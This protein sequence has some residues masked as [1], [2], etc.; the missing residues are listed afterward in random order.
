ME[1]LTPMEEK[2]TSLLNL[3]HPLNFACYPPEY[4]IPP[5]LSSSSS[6]STTRNGTSAWIGQGNFNVCRA[7]LKK[8]LQ[9]TNTNPSTS[10]AS[11]WLSLP[12]PSLTLQ[13]YWVGVSE[14]YYIVHDYYGLSDTFLNMGT[15]MNMSQAFCARPYPGQDPRRGR[16]CLKSAWLSTLLLDGYASLF[17]PSN[18]SS[19]SLSSSSF[20]SNEDKDKDKEDE[21][22]ESSLF[23]GWWWSSFQNNPANTVQPK[24]KETDDAN[25]PPG[26]ATCFLNTFEVQKAKTTLMTSSTLT[27]LSS[28][29]KTIDIA[30]HLQIN[31]S[32]LLSNLSI[33]NETPE[34]PCFIP[35]Q[36]LCPWPLI[37]LNTLDQ[38]ELSWTYGALLHYQFLAPYVTF[39]TPSSLTPLSTFP[40]TSLHWFEHTSIVGLFMVCGWVL[41]VLRKQQPRFSTPFTSFFFRS[42]PLSSSNSSMSTMSLLRR[43]S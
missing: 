27:S 26:C 11:T 39:Q 7:Q 19:S 24:K 15:L 21:D 28:L 37:P 25:T 40:S 32:F 3:S 6:S 12:P 2:E 4:P 9:P 8:Y 13:P 36:D 16:Q 33:P 5:P 35:Q 42:N 18:S 29:I 10:M 1:T 14:Y 34:Q 23:R 43:N 22:R 31:Y 20:F 38:Q 17:L 41:L 30:P